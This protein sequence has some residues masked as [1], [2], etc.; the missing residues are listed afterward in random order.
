MTS[1]VS[2]ACNVGRKTAFFYGGNVLRRW[3]EDEIEWIDDD[4]IDQRYGKYNYVT[5]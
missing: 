3:F 5:Q 2:N 1:R 4:E